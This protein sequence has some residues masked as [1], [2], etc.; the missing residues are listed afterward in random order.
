MGLS[1]NDE[2]IGAGALYRTG[3]YLSR[4]GQLKTYYLWHQLLETLEKSQ[5]YGAPQWARASSWLE[6][7]R[8]SDRYFKCSDSNNVMS[9]ADCWFLFNTA[10]TGNHQNSSCLLSTWLDIKSSILIWVV[11]AWTHTVHRHACAHANAHTRTQ[12]DLTLLPT[13]FQLI[14]FQHDW[15]YRIPPQSPSP[16]LQSAWANTVYRAN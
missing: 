11:S 8:F 3:L 7:F 16:N 2:V 6:E 14:Y 12:T 4:H 5:P 9:L 15:A 10:H 13:L 1:W